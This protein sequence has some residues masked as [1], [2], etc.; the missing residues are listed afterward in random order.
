VLY[1]IESE[2]RQVKDLSGVWQFRLDKGDEG[3][4]KKWYR[5]GLAGA[6][7]MPVPASYNDMTQDVAVRDHIGWAWYEREFFAAAELEGRQVAMRVGSAAHR[8]KMWV[9]GKLVAEHKGGYLPFEGDVADELNYGGAN[10]VTIAVDNRLDWTTL[11]PGFIKEHKDDLHP[12]G[13]RT[14]EY[15]FDF[16]NYSGIHRPVRL[17]VTPKNHIE[18][19]T[20]VT[21][22]KGK[23]GIVRYDIKTKGLKSMSVRLIDEAGRCVAEGSG[24]KGVLK[25]KNA[26]LWRPGKAYLYTLE[27]NGLD[28]KGGLVDRYRLA[29]GIR[30]VAVRGRQ[31]LINGK[32]FY[33]KGFGKHE[34]A[35]LR[36]KGHDDVTNVKDFNLLAWIGANS[37]RTSHYPY[38]EEIMQLADRYGIV[39]IDEAPGVGMR[40]WGNEKEALFGGL[41]TSETLEH[42]LQVMRELV[43]RDKNHP[44]VVMW[45]VANEA[46]TEEPGAD[47]Y[48]GRVLKE[49]RRLDATRPVTIVECAGWEKTRASG[50]F[51]VVCVNRYFSWYS[52]QGHL[53][54]V[55]KQVENECRRWYKR[56][57]KPVIMSEYG[58]D[59][60]PGMHSEPAIMFTEEFQCQMLDAYQRAFDKLDFVIGEHVW[61]FADFQTKQGVMRVMGNKKG[62]FTRD[63]QPKAAAHMLRKRW[64]NHKK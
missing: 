15:M 7:P 27:V 63:R 8:A 22:I 52:D 55:E 36:G 6:M 46:K 41:I 13:Y 2:T 37:F 5:T 21:D 30:T 35:A 17:V 9:N 53:E 61:N 42:H 58:A 48:F 11:P 18:D 40:F 4:K 60:I 57:K 10:R 20:V 59:T 62:V 56:F 31:F 39:V 51:D 32:P 49:T 24:V 47:R 33:F 38:S 45:S 23:D 19:I 34:D 54:L 43:A 50:M 16:F 64:L 26:K 14:Q 28:K 29:V 25:V 12:K 1:P 3:F 44:C